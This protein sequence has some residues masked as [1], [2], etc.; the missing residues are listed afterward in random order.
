MS[1]PQ[2]ALRNLEQFRFREGGGEELDSDR[3]AGGVVVPGGNAD[4]A[5]AGEVQRDGEDVREV[6]LKRVGLFAELERDGRRGR[7]E[8]HV[9]LPVGLFKIAPDQRAHLLGA[10]VVGVVVTAGEHVGPQQDAPL[11]LAAESFA[12]G[13]VVGVDQVAPLLAVPVADAGEPGGRLPARETP[14]R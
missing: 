10:E 8:H 3:H 6:H 1:R 11:D 4:A 2:E 7:C 13:L 14:R 9:A 5:V 12:A